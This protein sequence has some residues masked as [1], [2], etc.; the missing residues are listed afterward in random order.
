MSSAASKDQKVD[1][2]TTVETGRFTE[3][4]KKLDSD[5]VRSSEDGLHSLTSARVTVSP[6]LN[7]E[8]C[9]IDDV[10]WSV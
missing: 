2:Q 6:S 1:S 9:S 10:H 8:R 3:D 5:G 4:V 7:V